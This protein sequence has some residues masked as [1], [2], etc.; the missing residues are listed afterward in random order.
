MSP[1]WVIS[2]S[3]SLWLLGKCSSSLTWIL[4]S[5]TFPALTSPCRTNCSSPKGPHCVTPVP[6]ASPTYVTLLSCGNLLQHMCFAYLHAKSLQSCLPFFNPVDRSLLSSSVHRFL[7]ARTL[8]WV[9]MPSRGS[10]WPRDQTHVS[11]LL[12]W[13]M[14]SLP[15]VP[16]GTDTETVGN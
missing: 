8:E 4:C 3:A 5:P 9:A 14:C 7:H 12:H 6:S 11:C 10:S 1:L 16:P 2:I 13:Q 15:I